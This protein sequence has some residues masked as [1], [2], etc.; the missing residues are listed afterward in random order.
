VTGT[1]GRVITTTSKVQ[2]GVVGVKIWT[3]T[4]FPAGISAASMTYSI[5]R[6]DP[7]TGILAVDA[8]VRQRGHINIVIHAKLVQWF[9]PAGVKTLKIS[10]DKLQHWL[11]LP[12]S[13]QMWICCYH[14]HSTSINL[15]TQSGDELHVSPLGCWHRACAISSVSE[16]VESPIP[17]CNNWKHASI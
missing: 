13:T 2:L 10:L 9:A 8:K 6:S 15:A 16:A 14:I 17:W 5:N 4:V 12:V 1:C 11:F 3:E 7:T